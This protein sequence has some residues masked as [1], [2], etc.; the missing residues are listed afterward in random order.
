MPK[1]F[2]A[3]FV[4]AL[5]GDRARGRLI[6]GGLHLPCALGPA[7]IVVDKREGDGA[8]PRAALKIRRVWRRAD[9]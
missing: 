8:T 4:R 2:R 7:G 3:V 1:P 5:T 9:R 6:A